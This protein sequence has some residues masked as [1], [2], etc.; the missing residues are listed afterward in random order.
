[1]L[2]TFNCG[3]GF[4]VIVDQAD[5]A[6][7]SKLLEQLGEAPVSIGEIVSKEEM[8]RDTEILI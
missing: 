5:A 3:I 7:T 8:I 1:M 4:L 6:R 2:T